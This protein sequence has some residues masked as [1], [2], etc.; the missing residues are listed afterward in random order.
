MDKRQLER[1][2][3]DRY[4]ASADVT[5]SD[6]AVEQFSEEL[7]AVVAE[8]LPAGSAVLEA[9]S[10]GG[11]QSLALARAGR[12][13]LTLMDFAANALA[14]AEHVFDHQGV[15]AT[16]VEGDVFAPGEAEFDLVFNAGVLE[17]YTLGEQIDFLKGMASRS[18]RYVLAIVPNR[19]CYWYWIWR[20]RVVLKGDWPFGKEVPLLDLSAAF[21]G[22]G[23]RF[24]GQTFM[25]D[26]WTEDFINSVGRSGAQEKPGAIN[27]ELCK[28]IIQVHRSPLIPKSQKSYLVAALG[29]VIPNDNAP[30]VWTKPLLEQGQELAELSAALAEALAL[31][32]GSEERS[33]SLQSRV[34]SLECEVAR[35]KSEAEAQRSVLAAREEALKTALY[36]L[37]EI[38][39]SRYWSLLTLYWH[40][41]ASGRKALNRVRGD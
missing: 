37:Q 21:E 34:T 5:A 6:I 14:A 1:E 8:L 16:F 29:S 4:Y 2:K 7:A 38:H 15:S 25:G 24:I 33:L 13:R 18:N 23:L 22:A 31:T 9:G 11:H 32:I 36:D 28:Q 30:P 17:H 35:L 27:D 3:W 20:M 26:G 10:G 12:F 19:Y 39:G 41:V 40:A